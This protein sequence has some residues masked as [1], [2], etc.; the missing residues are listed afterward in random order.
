MRHL[1]VQE[2][3]MVCG[4]KNAP[5]SK[6]KPQPKSDPCSLRKFADAGWEGGIAGA[7]G[8]AILGSVTPGIGTVTGA[9][10]GFVGG[11]ATAMADRGYKC[12][13]SKVTTWWGQAS[14]EANT[15]PALRTELPFQFLGFAKRAPVLGLTGE[16]SPAYVRTRVPGPTL[17]VYV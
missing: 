1:Y 4:G 12:G 13:K 3:P 15:F 14:T 8:G 10:T 9:A 6:S 5:C 2:L 11:A 17:C 7:V 16:A